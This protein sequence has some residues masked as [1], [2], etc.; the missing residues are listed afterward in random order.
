MAGRARSVP[1][2][3]TAKSWQRICRVSG[4]M[5]RKEHTDITS[6]ARGD[7]HAGVV[8][9]SLCNATCLAQDAETPTSLS[10]CSITAT[11]RLRRR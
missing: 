6:Q 11:A 7:G 10:L 8:R 9:W 2:A 1:L 4:A 3:A 5:R